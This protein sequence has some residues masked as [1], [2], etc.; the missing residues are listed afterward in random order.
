MTERIK[1]WLCSR[2]LHMLGMVDEPLYGPLNALAN[3]TMRMRKPETVQ[4]P[5]TLHPDKT[6][7]IIRDLPPDAGLASWHD[8]VLGYVMRA[9][10]K[11]WIPVVDPPPPAQADSGTWYDY[12]KPVSEFSPEEALCGR[13]VVFA[14]M[15]GMIYKRFNMRNIRKRHETASRRIAY[16]DKALR[17][18]EAGVHALIDRIG[19]PMVGIRFRGTDYRSK[20]EWKPIGHAVVPDVQSF[21]D[22]AVADMKRWGVPVGDGEHIFLMTEEQEAFD[23]I[24][25]R[26]PACHFIERERFSNFDFNS[27][28]CLCYHRLPN[29]TPLEN[30]LNYL[31]EIEILSRCDYMMGG[32]NGGV[33]MACNLNGGAY[34]GIHLLKTGVS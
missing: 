25:E 33:L 5:G 8:R 23:S 16:S 4:H 9:E 24:R 30:N 32:Y 15:Q 18:I 28:K 20:G 34:R 13:N 3:L 27:G 10:R 14:T 11:G 19:K 22:A 26:F 29:T 2:A 12:F 31:L 1:G 21:C 17:F 6:F 7:Y